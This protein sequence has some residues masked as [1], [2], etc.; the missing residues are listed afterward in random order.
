MNEAPELMDPLLLHLSSRVLTTLQKNDLYRLEDI[1]S[2]TRSDLLGLKQIGHRSANEIIGLLMDLHVTPGQELSEVPVYT[3]AEQH[4]VQTLSDGKTGLWKNEAVDRYHRATLRS[5]TLERDAL[6][7]TFIT[8]DR[9][10]T[11]SASGED[12]SIVCS[13]G[14]DNCETH[15]LTMVL[16]LIE[17]RRRRNMP[18]GV[19]PVDETTHQP[20]NRDP[21]FFG[22]K[23]AT[24]ECLLEQGI[25]WTEELTALS[26]DRIRDIPGIG[27]SRYEEIKEMLTE[28]GLEPGL[29]TASEH[30]R[31]ADRFPVDV[32][33]DLIRLRRRTRADR[34]EKI[35]RD[36][37]VRDLERTT[38]HDASGQIHEKG[39]TYE[40]VLNRPTGEHRCSCSRNTERSPCHHLYALALELAKR[41]R[42]R[43]LST[44]ETD[45]MSDDV[46][47]L[48]SSLERHRKPDD[49]IAPAE[50]ESGS[51]GDVR[52][53]LFQ[54]D[55]EW[56]LY[57]SLAGPD[58]VTGELPAGTSFVSL[59]NKLVRRAPRHQRSLLRHLQSRYRE[60]KADARDGGV[61][62]LLSLLVDEPVFIQTENGTFREAEFV[63]TTGEPVLALEKTDDGG[64]R[65][66][67]KL[68]VGDDRI[69]GG[70]L[71]L[72]S[73]RPLWI[74]NGIR[75]I[76]AETRPVFADLLTHRHGDPIEVP[77]GE[78][79]DAVIDVLP[80]LLD[81]G[82]QVSVPENVPERTME[83]ERA[84]KLTDRSDQLLVEPR[85]RYG[86]VEFSRIQKGTVLVPDPEGD[87]VRKLD[88][89]VEKE[90]QFL[91]FLKETGL[92][93]APEYHRNVL[94]PGS[95]RGR[96]LIEE[97]PRLEEEGIEVITNENL[98][99]P[100]EV[101]DPETST[102]EIRGGIEWFEVEGEIQYEERTAEL[103]EVLETIR[104][105][106]KYIQLSEGSY[107]KIPS[108]LR[109]R[110]AGVDEYARQTEEAMELPGLSIPRL[111]SLLESV[112]ETETDETIEKYRRFYREFD[113]IDDVREPD[114]FQG[115]LRKYQR[116]G[117]AWLKFLRE[118]GFGGLLADDM[119]LGKTVQILAHLHRV[120]VEERAGDDEA[121]PDSLV[122][123]PRSVLKNWER[124][125]KRF[126]PDPDLYVHH[127]RGRVE[128][129]DEWPSHHL[130][131]TTYGTMRSDVA[132]LKERRFDTIVLDECQA[133]RNP[134]TRTA[135]KVRLLEADCRI[136]LSGTPVQNTVLDLWSQFQFLNPG[137]LGDR[138]Y[139]EHHFVRPIEEEGESEVSDRLQQMIHPFLLRRTK[140]Q[141]EQQL[142]ELSRSI[143][144]CPLF[145]E[146]K[147]LYETYRKRYRREV[148]NTIQQQ[149][150]NQSRF[151]VLE[152][153]T[154]LRQ[155]CCHPALVEEEGEYGDETS[156][157]LVRFARQAEEVINEGH[158]ALVFSQFVSFLQHIREAV[159]GRG[160]GYEYLD[161][162]T[163]NREERVRRFQENET[164]KLFLISLKAGGEGLNLTGADYVF[165][166][167]PWWNPAVE[168]QAMDRTH[169]IG[170][171]R[172]VFVYRLICPDTIEEKMLGLQE[173]KKE[174]ARDIVTPEAGVFK[175]L[176]R[177]ELLAL[178]E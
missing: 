9:E 71:D 30:D 43:I 27:P 121:F 88:R 80:K 101:S 125:A 145:P 85:F 98:K 93:P 161:G 18:D 16:L 115:T 3:E 53:Y 51:D 157:K 166:M 87:G 153:L 42:T 100:P 140:E 117:L 31:P 76:P 134:N 169:R 130:T 122:I 176:D 46:A 50:Q 151:K 14:T 173:K 58:E 35:V 84:V 111:E 45:R 126:L 105:G 61:G 40:T 103:E 6:E 13:C 94:T 73:S 55:G 170:Q 44:V 90:R 149:G 107:G 74:R 8:G 66:V 158:R 109:N 150:I 95:S 86:E 29:P 165:L 114:S 175:D 56:L 124:E 147:D 52:Y 91:S 119:G 139:F 67:P 21:L 54:R 148:T 47:W 123:C 155:I 129:V 159:E 146:Q 11:V 96:W 167:D 70:Q 12:G 62:E 141:V 99:D 28:T 82:L 152:G 17:R 26:P 136:G 19:A 38:G 33:R 32:A 135:R 68:D 72:V 112:E 78:V 89:N 104:E 39:R 83:P 10:R 48:L 49:S 23:P 20:L 22:L 97:R 77:V 37:D 142:P 4:W 163:R 75:L 59:P 15:A 60:D 1:S 132:M 178:F 174:L 154:R 69:P 116:A 7:G 2:F 128:E 127:G 168:Q 171:D 41:I 177:D 172:P 79:S 65:L 25:L 57:P 162:S 137:L 110:F 143:L 63:E 106:R 92:E 113:G 102:A 120:R 164:R 81:H 64:F 24:R 144:D 5:G 156:T 133:I 131:L 34:G 118:Y 160:W 36:G 108:D 138:S